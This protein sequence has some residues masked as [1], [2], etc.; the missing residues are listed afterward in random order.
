MQVKSGKKML[1][2]GFYNA[3]RINSTYTL[4]GWKI[5]EFEIEAIASA[6]SKKQNQILCNLVM[7]LKRRHGKSDAQINFKCLETFLTASF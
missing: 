5:T 2:T 6:T 3:I 1:K 4:T 7:F